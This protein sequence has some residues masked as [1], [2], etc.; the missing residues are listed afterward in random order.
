MRFLH[1]LDHPEAVVRFEKQ[2]AMP[3]S[4]THNT[5]ENDDE[6]L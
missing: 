6:D 3:E 2:P 1:T 5:K 4:Q